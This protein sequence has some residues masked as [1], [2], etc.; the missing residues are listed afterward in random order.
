MHG[1]SIRSM[2]CHYPPYMSVEPPSQQHVPAHSG[3]TVGGKHYGSVHNSQLDGMNRDL[4]VRQGWKV[5]YDKRHQTVAILTV[6]DEV[7]TEFDF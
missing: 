6:N 1:A 5:L 3:M 2:V 4:E 7:R